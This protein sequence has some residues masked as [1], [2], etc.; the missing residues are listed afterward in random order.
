MIRKILYSAEVR[1]KQEIGTYYSYG[2]F[3]S[4]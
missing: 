3:E 2:L 1:S 4:M